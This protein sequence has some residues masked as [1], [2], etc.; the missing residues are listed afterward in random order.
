MLFNDNEIVKLPVNNGTLEIPKFLNGK[1][2]MIWEIL[3]DHYDCDCWFT[4]EKVKKIIIHAYNLEI[5]DAFSQ[6]E[7]LEELEIYE[8][9]KTLSYSGL[10]KC[11][12][13]KKLTIGRNCSTNTLADIIKYARNI[14]EL[15]IYGV[16]NHYSDYMFSDCINLNPSC[17]IN[18]GLKG[19]FE[20]AFKNCKS[21]IHVNL[22]KSLK[23]I[24]LDAFKG[25]ENIK[26][27]RIN[28]LVGFKDPFYIEGSRV[29]LLDNSPK[30]VVYHP[31]GYPVNYLVKHLSD[32]I[33]IEKKGT[34]NLPASRFSASSL[35]VLGYKCIQDIPGN[36]DDLVLSLR[37]MNDGIWRIY[38]INEIDT[39]IRS[40]FLFI[41][42]DNWR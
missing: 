8:D 39:T 3:T 1:R 41:F 16:R 13:L 26:T 27:L 12:K 19:I 37:Y 11:R 21:F 18:E 38:L 22:P 24:H 20:G 32:N 2:I 17:V 6:F 9:V 42:T 10:H 15:R 31:E 29:R 36:K 5:N 33:T 14:H 34:L 25:C 30:A 28:S 7:N 23:L 40:N 4:A 35:K